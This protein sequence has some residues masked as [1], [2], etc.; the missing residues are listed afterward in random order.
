MQLQPRS[1]HEQM[2]DVWR[3]YPGARLTA[4]N[5]HAVKWQVTL[6]NLALPTQPKFPPYACYNKAETDLHI[7]LPSGFP[8]AKPE[9]F[10][11]DGDL[12]CEHGGFP[13]YTDPFLRWMWE[14][15][16]TLRWWIRPSV[17][18]PIRD[19]IYTYLMFSKV[20]LWRTAVGGGK[21]GNTDEQ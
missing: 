8:F 10:W 5:S 2:S 14:P 1:V 21:L 12:R 18:N 16:N 3:R 19:T 20:H 11:T 15:A 4:I 9:L 17:W 7:L 13:S 6:P